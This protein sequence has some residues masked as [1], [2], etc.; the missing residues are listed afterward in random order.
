MYLIGIV[1]DPSKKHKRIVN[2]LMTHRRLR[3]R[4]HPKS[5]LLKRIHPMRRT[6]QRNCWTCPK[7]SK[8]RRN[9]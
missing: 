8:T 2:R 9:W 5:L 1:S 7:N 3:T 6:R 4:H